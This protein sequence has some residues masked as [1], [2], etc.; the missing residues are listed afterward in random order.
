MSGPFVF[1]HPHPLQRYLWLLVVLST[2]QIHFLSFDP[3]FPARS[4][5]LWDLHVTYSRNDQND[6]HKMHIALNILPV[7]EQLSPDQR[8]TDSLVMDPPL[9]EAA[10]PQTG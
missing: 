3:L 9:L 1:G 6:T 10:E 7:D 8:Q 5:F 2:S 4:G